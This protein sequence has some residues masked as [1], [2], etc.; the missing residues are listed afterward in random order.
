LTKV[1]LQTSVGVKSS[2]EILFTE[3]LISTIIV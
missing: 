2:T 3:A 1:H